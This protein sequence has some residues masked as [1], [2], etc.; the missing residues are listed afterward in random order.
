MSREQLENPA[1]KYFADASELNKF[2]E[3]GRRVTYKCEIT[4]A[5]LENWNLLLG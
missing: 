1:A 3:A 2:S 4:G 5:R